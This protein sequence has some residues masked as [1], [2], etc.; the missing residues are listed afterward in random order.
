MERSNREAGKYCK[1]CAWIHV[2]INVG[3]NHCD[4]N[5]NEEWNELEKRVNGRI[6]Y[7]NGHL[8]DSECCRYF[9]DEDGKEKP[10]KEGF[11]YKPPKDSWKKC[12]K[13]PQFKRDKIKQMI[14]NKEI[15]KGLKC[16]KEWIESNYWNEFGEAIN[17]PK[18]GDEIH[19]S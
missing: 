10:T 9:W 6:S 11:F 18:K 13:I 19:A 8:Y 17:P 15:R 3:H 16:S 7:L 2:G 14:K 5:D 12:P 4:Y 1:G